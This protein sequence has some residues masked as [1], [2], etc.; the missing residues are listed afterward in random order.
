MVT[1]TLPSG[2]ELDNSCP[3]SHKCWADQGCIDPPECPPTALDVL[4]RA[5]VLEHELGLLPHDD[6]DIAAVC[7][8]DHPKD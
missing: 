1:V 3:F 8:A 5:A 6:P 4:R 7:T 2:R